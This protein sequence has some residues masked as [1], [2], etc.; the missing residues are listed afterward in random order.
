MAV[1]LQLHVCIP[2]HLFIFI[3]QRVCT[4]AYVHQ[5]SEVLSYSSYWSRNKTS[6]RMCFVFVS[7]Q[8]HIPA[9]INPCTIVHKALFCEMWFT[10]TWLAQKF[11]IV[12]LET[13]SLNDWKTNSGLIFLY[14]VELV[15]FYFMI[16]WMSLILLSK[17]YEVSADIM[18]LLFSVCMESRAIAGLRW[19][20]Q[21]AVWSLNYESFMSQWWRRHKGTKPCWLS[22]LCT[23]AFAVLM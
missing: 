14:C 19:W 10:V 18:V 15:W 9:G 8:L 16:L 5:Q 3:Y 12:W 22:A 2:V 20:Y 21:Q 1:C 6:L 17:S 7:A 13:T 11:V 4:L 23:E